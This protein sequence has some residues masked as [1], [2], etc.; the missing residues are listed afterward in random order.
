VNEVYFG[1]SDDAS[2]HDASLYYQTNN[3][4]PW[5]IAINIGESE[6]WFHP[7]KWVSI[8]KAYPKF[9]DYATSNGVVNPALFQNNNAALA[10]TYHY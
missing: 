5:G 1:L 8:L 4:V 10:K 6:N 3:G 2:D 9:E 7:Y